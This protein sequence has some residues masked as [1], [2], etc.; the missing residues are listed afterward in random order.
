MSFGDPVEFVRNL[1][2]GDNQRCGNRV[3]LEDEDAG[4]INAANPLP[5]T[6]VIAGGLADP[7]P[8]TLEDAAGNPAGIAANPIQIGDAGATLSVDDAGG[9]LTVDQATHDNLNANANLQVGNADVG[10]ANPVPVNAR[11]GTTLTC[12]RHGRRRD[13]QSRRHQH[14]VVH[15]N[16]STTKTAT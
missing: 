7:L 13:W 4:A 5:T 6:A 14:Q 8:V 16:R 2:N 11:A 10:A 12:Q 3:Q 15:S 9:T 1:L